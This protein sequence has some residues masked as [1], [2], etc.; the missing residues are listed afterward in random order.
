MALNLT[1][2]KKSGTTT[3]TVKKEAQVYQGGGS[4]EF[5]ANQIKNPAHICWQTS[6]PPTTDPTRILPVG[7]TLQVLS[8]H[9][10]NTSY[11]PAYIKVLSSTG[12]TFDIMAQDIG[13][14]CQ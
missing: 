8:I 14:F 4:H 10:P 13:R 12:R 6:Y 2:I 11:A 3:L 9:P 1:T 5:L 7:T